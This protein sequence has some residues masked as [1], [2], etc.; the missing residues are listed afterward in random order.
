MRSENV[1]SRVTRSCRE[2]L[3]VWSNRVYG[4]RSPR[5]RT[6]CA[7]QYPLSSMAE[8]QAQVT[9][10]S[11]PC[12][13]VHLFIDKLD[14]ELVEQPS[15]ICSPDSSMPFTDCELLSELS[16]EFSSLIENQSSWHAKWSNP[17]FEK[18][19]P[20]DFRMLGIMAITPKVLA[21]LRMLMKLNW[22]PS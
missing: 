8:L 16:L 3:P 10:A 4:S 1:L 7:G 6:H 18:V 9:A 19:V 22:L 21:K 12:H 20:H 13:A 5:P 11:E 14:A 15:R 17:V 2:S